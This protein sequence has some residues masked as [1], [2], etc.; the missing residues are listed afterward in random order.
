MLVDKYPKMLIVFLYSLTHIL[1]LII[2]TFS[3]SSPQIYSYHMYYIWGIPS[4]SPSPKILVVLTPLHIVTAMQISYIS[5][6]GHYICKD[7]SDIASPG[8][9]MAV[10]FLLVVSVLILPVF[11]T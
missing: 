6:C 8:S 2:K 4:P 5:I 10:H 7:V 1:I 9:F 11:F 3:Y